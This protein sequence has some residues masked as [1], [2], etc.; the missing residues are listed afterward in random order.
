M[1]IKLNFDYKV[2]ITSHNSPDVCKSAESL[3]TAGCSKDRIFIVIDD[4]DPRFEEYVNMDYDVY[5]FHKQDYVDILD[6]GMSKM[7]PQLSAVLYARAAVEDIAKSMK[8]QYFIVMDDDVYGFRYRYVENDK[9]CSKPVHNFDDLIFAYV[10][11]ME[12]SD[13]ICLSFANDG[14]FI[15]GSDAV[16]SGKILERRS[17]HT[18]FIRRTDRE[19]EWKFAVNEDYVSSLLYANIGKLMFTLP[20]VQRTISGMNNRIEGM[21]DLYENTTDFQRAFYNVIAC[22]WTCKV[23][24][25]KNTYVVR[26]N[27]DSA[28]P[29]IISDRYRR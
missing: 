23:A 5:V 17:C 9:L 15:G 10:K 18:I 13:S 24:L 25:Y 2:F 27:K 7:N 19:F 16:T 6:I 12:N 20:F 28:Y 21:H 26:T 14:S 4:A 3:L 29:K 11:F 8:L 22:P 1:E